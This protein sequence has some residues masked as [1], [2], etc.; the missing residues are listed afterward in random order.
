VG[1]CG[2]LCQGPSDTEADLDPNNDKLA[3][4]LVDLKHVT[5]AERCLV[6]GDEPVV[7]KGRLEVRP[8]NSAVGTRTVEV[9]VAESVALLKPKKNP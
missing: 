7:V 8:D 2:Y 3:G 9:I 1:A 4:F 5:G 6:G